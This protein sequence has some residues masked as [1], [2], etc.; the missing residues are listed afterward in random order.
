MGFLLVY[1]LANAGG[2]LGYLPLLTLLLPVKIEKLAGEGRIGLFSMAV[3][4]GALAASASHVAFGMLN[5]RAVARGGGRRRWMAG[6]V[7]ALAVSY[8]GV[9]LAASPGA[10][11]AAIVVFQIAVNAMLNPLAAIMADEIPDEQKGMA[12]GLLAFA[13][14]FASAL[15]TVIVSIAA[16]ESAQLAIIAAFIALCATPLLLA[17][18]RP[19]Q[20]AAC[21]GRPQAPVRRDLALAWAS[22]LLVQIAGNALSLYLLY[23]FQSVVAGAAP[24]ALQPRIANLLTVAYL[25]PL[26]IALVIGRSSDRLAR[27]KPFLLASAAMAAIGLVLMAVA[28]GW[29]I[30]IVGFVVY[31]IGSAVFLA[32]HSAF[33]MQLLPDPAHRGRDLGLLNLTN[34]LPAL[35][36][37]LL[38]W[39]LATPQ[40]FGV[41]MLA[42]A[43]LTAA[44]GLLVLAVQGWR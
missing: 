13:N 4:A 33:A 41:L 38:T 11:V 6:G 32:L 21:Q 43:V 37:P 15:A 26:P 9:A 2:V 30:A 23:Y 44:G 14:P 7:L 8:L 16:V 39:A 3:I 5:D 22:R 42:L 18:A 19:I 10:V 40:D 29:T 36:G 20:A 24:A 27:R 31:A 17:P 34:T 25:L 1:A 35:A 28:A 12:G